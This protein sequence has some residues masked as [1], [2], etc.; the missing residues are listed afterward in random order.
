MIIDFSAVHARR[1]K[2]SELAE[3]VG[4]DDLRQ[5]SIDSVGYLL[6]LLENLTDADVV[7]EPF[8]P[9]ADDP[10]AVEGEEHL[11]WNLAHL[12]AH[13]TASSEEAAA[14]SSLLARGVAATER[15]RYETPWRDL[16]T[17]AQC[18]QRL[19]ESLRMRLAY[20]DTWPDEPHLDVTR[21]LSPRFEERVGKLNAIGAF[22]HGLSHEVSHYGQIEEVIGQA[23][24]S[25]E[26]V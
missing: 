23:L 11:A 12:I 2:L 10:Y 13:V 25:R 16:T 26:R 21:Q 3:G 6:S 14:F 7:H 4:Q 17:R 18:E 5:A 22:L 20:L 1:Q 24:A 9:E 15:P 8:D 19:R